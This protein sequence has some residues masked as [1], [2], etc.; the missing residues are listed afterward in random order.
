MKKS[1]RNFEIYPTIEDINR[2]ELAELSPNLI[3]SAYNNSENYFETQFSLLREELVRP[4]VQSVNK[5]RE[6]ALNYGN[7]KQNKENIFNKN[8]KSFKELIESETDFN[9]Y[10][11]IQVLGIDV[12]YNCGL[13]LIVTLDHELLELIDWSVSRLQ[14]YLF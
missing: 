10:N 14:I 8:N 13:V 3:S 1:F 9:V 5:F 11:E 2:S 4:L 7:K 12:N 6:L